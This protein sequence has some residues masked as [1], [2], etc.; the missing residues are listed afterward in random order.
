VVLAT[1]IA[2][3]AHIRRAGRLFELVNRLD[4]VKMLALAAVIGTATLAR[5]AIGVPRWVSGVGV[6]AVLALIASGAGYLALNGTLADAAAV[7]L[8]LLLVWVLANALALGRSAVNRAA[9]ADGSVTG[10]GHSLRL[11]STAR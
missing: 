1:S 2:A 9:R 5:D 10:L 11:R 7:S 8:P 6:L 3:P 4:G